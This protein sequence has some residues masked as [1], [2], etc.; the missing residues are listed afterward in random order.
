MKRHNFKNFLKLNKENNPPKEDLQIT[1]YLQV[2]EEERINTALLYFSYYATGGWIRRF[3]PKA[4]PKEEYGY[5]SLMLRA[6]TKF[7]TIAGFEKNPAL[8]P[9]STFAF[10]NNFPSVSRSSRVPVSKYIP[11][12]DFV[13]EDGIGGIPVKGQDARSENIPFTNATTN[14]L[15]PPVYTVEEYKPIDPEL[16]FKMRKLNIN[17]NMMLD[18]RTFN[19]NRQGKRIQ[20]DLRFPDDNVANLL[21]AKEIN[22]FP[23][24]YFRRHGHNLYSIAAL[25]KW[26]QGII[27]FFFKH[28][29]E[30]CYIQDPNFTDPQYARMFVALRQFIQY[31]CAWMFPMDISYFCYWLH[32]YFIE[33]LKWLTMSL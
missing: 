2:S 18:L 28:P 13:T 25:T 1:H 20:V 24:M 3:Y 29:L 8:A 26:E 14:A 12:L 16:T 4:T 30:A 15:E 23:P 10:A 9:L 33:V 11:A 21:F 22:F 5:R 31:D 17:E 32:D 6:H 7:D 19:I 27:K